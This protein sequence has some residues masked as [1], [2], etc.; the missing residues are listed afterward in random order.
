MKH[1][2]ILR[3]A[4]FF[5]SAL[6]ASALELK[7]GDHV[8]ITGNTFGEQ[9][10]FSGYLE[11]LLHA[12]NGDKEIV[13]RNLSWSADT[14]TLKPRPQDC[15]THDQFLTKYGATVIIGCYGLNE[16]YETPLPQFKKD[17]EAFIDHT[18]AQKYDGA[19]PPRLV[20]ISP[21]AME[22]MDGPGLPV[23]RTRNQVIE[24]YVEVMAAVCKAKRVEFADIFHPLLE[25]YAKESKRKLTANGIHLN[26]D[27]ERFVSSGLDTLLFGPAGSLR[28]KW[29]PEKME[30]LRQAVNE[31]NLQFWYRYRPVNPF[32]IYGGRAAPFGT[33]SFPPEME[34]LDGMVANRDRKI[35]DIAQ[36]KTMD[37]KVDDSN[38][39]PVPETPSTMKEDPKINSPEEERQTFTVL[40]GFE[41]SLFASEVEF[42]DLK[43]PV[44]LTF[45]AK[46]RMW[47]TTIPTYPHLFPGQEPQDKLLILTDKDS[48]GK[49]DECKTFADHLY[50]PTGL[51]LG[52]GGAY[53][54][55]EPN[56]IFLKDTNGDDK[57]D[58]TTTLLRGFGTEDSHHAINAF[59]WGPGGGL[60]MME[61]TF[62]HSQVETPWGPVRLENAGVW[63]Y[64]PNTEKL[65]VYVTYNYA[66]PWGE[67][68]DRWGRNYIADASGGDNHYGNA[69]SGWLPYPQK[70]D[71]ME[72]FTDMKAHLRPTAGCEVVSSRQFPDQYQQW[73]L[74]NNN[75]GFQGTRMFRV[76]DDGSGFKS[77]EWKDLIRS[78]DPSFR[79]VDLEFGPD[80]ALYIVDWY[81][82]IIGHM[83]FS[84]RDPK[85]DKAHGRIWRITAK[86]RETVKPAK[87]DGAKTPELLQLLRSYEDR[88][89]YRVRRELAQRDTP[90][91]L[92][93]IDRF[94]KSIPEK[95]A[96]REHLQLECLWVQQ[97][98]D[99]VDAALLKKVLASREPRARAAG[100]YVLRFWHDRIT[101]SAALLKAAAN[102][103]YP[104]VR[105]EAVVAASFIHSLAGVELALEAVKHPTDYY[106]D[107]ALKETMRA[108]EP[109]WKE[110]VAKGTSF[111]ADNPQ[112]LAWLLG[113]FTNSEVLS[114]PKTPEVWTEILRREGMSPENLTAAV[115]ALAVK[116]KT[117]VS[118]MLAALPQAKGTALASVFAGWDAKELKAGA[119]GIVKLVKEAKSQ[120]V[121]EAALA[122]LIPV[123]DGKRA[124]TLVKDE[125][126]GVIALCNALRLVS[127][128]EA[129]AGMGDVLS[130]LLEKLPESLAAKAKDGAAP[131]RF[132]RIEL[133]RKGTLSLTEVEVY[134]GGK[135]V[136]LS[137]TA[138]QSS[139]AHGGVAGRA[140]DGNTHG[141]WGRG[142]TT[143][144]EI[145]E[146]NPW[147]EVDLGRIEPIDKIAIVNR[148]DPVSDLGKRLN[149]FRLTILDN[150]RQPVFVYNHG[151]AGPRMEIPVK[152]DGAAG[153]RSA[154]VRAFATV[155]GREA[156]KIARLLPLIQSAE[157]RAAAASALKD[158]DLAKAPA[159]ALAAV[160]AT[161]QEQ[162]P[163][164]ALSDRQ[165][166]PFT[167]AIQLVK[168]LA[169]R[170]PSAKDKLEALVSTE[171][172]VSL[173]LK[174]DPVQ[175][176]YEQKE[177]T[178]RAGS[179]VA[180]AFE[181]PGEMPHNA[182]ICA[183]GS[184]EK[185]GAAADAM[186]TDPNGLAAG[187]VP[188]IP[189]VLYKTRLLN[190]GG[191]ETLIFRVPAAPGDYVI[192]CTFPGHWRL[193]KGVLKVTN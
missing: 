160:A 187:F 189:E 101:D 58:V 191:K 180:L 96:E 33:V 135:N 177:L 85:R 88:T 153:L 32:Y 14:L 183:P 98:H 142:T 91:V 150:S 51:E 145:D 2:L 144:T 134:S 192:V 115:K 130:G 19:A 60:H 112:G 176:F 125:P 53:V 62:L 162:L 108:V 43:K 69:Y 9:L 164:V 184:L 185:V 122:A 137:G 159:A 15:P 21:V 179:V 127:S 131:G 124:W 79:P 59:V 129:R 86:G 25:Q 45:D 95:D 128:G 154:V 110:A 8:C 181:N 167:D 174:A 74:L 107:Y 126:A 171:A 41:V 64:E 13:V 113:R 28:E 20:L 92:A 31:K 57:A 49:A 182:V 80:G 1:S 87:I 10:Q 68:F 29:T 52:N 7:K 56:L 118:V 121:R 61:G 157:N 77:T 75:I 17:L 100:V 97:Q 81:N 156:E 35:W 93:A 178:A 123:D 38:L 165:D 66:N 117:P 140:I 50:L 71:H 106:I 11:A 105:M 18:L 146:A 102:D 99:A 78:S 67:T 6:S 139:V 89:R 3:T 37:L 114:I 163:K 24:E 55:A 173:T 30:T 149:G 90:N 34:R 103:E 36:G 82:P 119:D 76:V 143:H 158:L 147:W 73:W 48:D 190:R 22:Q 44:Q 94:L 166:A 5:A 120:D 39:K 12:R 148:N 54:S 141:E 155:P 151:D 168:N 65:G 136:A 188:Q 109:Y 132:V 161:L 46:G 83:Q 169:S 84:L 172:P 193:M 170:V 152:V 186:Q 4:A 70:H 138:S 63:R 72:R 27:G 104:V 116:G 40:D 23:A 26:E 175:L 16:S 47:V 42:G 111:A 133:P